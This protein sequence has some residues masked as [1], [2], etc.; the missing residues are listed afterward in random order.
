MSQGRRLEQRSYELVDLPS[1]QVL[2]SATWTHELIRTAARRRHP[3][4]LLASENAA[5]ATDV[6]VIA[7]RVVDERA[8][9]SARRAKA[10]LSAVTRPVGGRRGGGRAQPM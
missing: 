1:G 2:A 8:D 6:V 10:E 5:Q 4:E 9:K 7:R 3:S